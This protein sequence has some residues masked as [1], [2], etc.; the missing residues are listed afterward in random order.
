MQFDFHHMQIMEGNLAAGLRRH[1]D[2]IGHVQFSS[3]PE[4]NE[5]QHGE[6]NLH[7]L[8]DYLDELGYPGWIGCEYAAKAGTIEG[9]GWRERYKLG[10]KRTTARDSK[11]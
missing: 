4:R 3:L 9:L 8:S 1:L 10:E 7:F 2:I 6:V 5:P 11:G